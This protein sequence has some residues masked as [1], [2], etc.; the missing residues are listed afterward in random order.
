M[1]VLSVLST[2]YALLWIFEIF[3]FISSLKYL[4]INCLQGEHLVIAN[5]GDSRAVLAT[6]SDDGQLVPLQ[7]SIDFKPNLTR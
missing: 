3:K 6:T 1:Q 5:V 4:P 2:I 7:L